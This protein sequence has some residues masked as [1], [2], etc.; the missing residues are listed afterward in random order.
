M[1]WRQI[2]IATK[3][4]VIRDVEILSHDLI[5]SDIGSER[6][7]LYIS[8]AT[9]THLQRIPSRGRNI[10]DCL[11]DVLFP[12]QLTWCL[13][14]AELERAFEAWHPLVSSTLGVGPISYATNTQSRRLDESRWNHNV[15]SAAGLAQ[16]PGGVWYIVYGMTLVRIKLDERF[17]GTDNIKRDH[18]PFRQ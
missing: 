11:L 6:P 4:V 17:A 7:P 10:G 3:Q 1:S 9:P 8:A 2:L 18:P 16:R 5:R 14:T 13:V 15:D 12:M